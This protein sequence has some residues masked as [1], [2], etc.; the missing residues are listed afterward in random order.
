MSAAVEIDGRCEARFAAVRAAFAAN[1]AAGREVG[2]SFA[3][4][5]DGVP[6]VDLWGG[7]IDAAR[8]RPWQR[9]TIVN[10]FSTTKAITALCAH[11]LVERGLLDVDAPVARYW[12]EFAEHGKDGIAVRHVLSHSAGLAALRRPLPTEALFDWERMVA[13]LAAETPWWEP[14]SVSGYHAMT[15]GHLVGELIRRLTGLTPGAFCRQVITEPLGADF[16]IGLPAMEDGRVADMVVPSHEENAAAGA[17]I[18]PESLLGKV[19]GNPPLRPELANTRAWRAAEI[20]PPTGMAMPGRW[21]GSWPRSPAAARSTACGCSQPR[22]WNGRFASSR[23][24][25]T[26]CSASRCAGDSATC[27]RAPSCR[28]GP[29]RAPSATVGGADRWRSR[30]STRA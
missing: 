30:I 25:A 15:Y 23:T 11:V 27:W 7:H 21:L 5:V 26:W 19:L 28:S 9:D 24:A 13:A 4:T 20:P 12:P 18:D 3:A 17:A 29:T 10:L 6:V 2:A 1:F 14:G 16:H 8:S 22:P